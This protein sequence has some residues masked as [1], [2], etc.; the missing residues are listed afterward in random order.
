MTPSKLARSSLTSTAPIRGTKAHQSQPKT[1]G[2]AARLLAV[3]ALSTCAMMTAHAAIPP[4]ERAVLQDIYTYTDGDNWF[5]PSRTGWNGAPGTECQWQGIACNADGDSVIAV[6]LVGAEL[7]GSLP[8]L[9]GLP[10][11]EVFDVRGVGSNHN[12]LYGFIPELSSLHKLQEFRAGNNFMTG[13]IPSLEG[14]GDLR[15]FECYQ[16]QLG[17]NIP[18]LNGLHEL[19]FFNVSRNQ[20]TGSLPALTGLNKLVY[21]DAKENHLTGTLPP[22]VGLTRLDSFFAYSNM[23]SGDVPDLIGLPELTHYS[24]GR[25]LL[26]GRIGILSDLPKLVSFDVSRN[27]LT[28]SLP[29]LDGLSS[30]QVLDAARNRL[31]GNVPDLSAASAL[32]GFFIQFNQLEGSL[33][34]PPASLVAA[35]QGGGS[36]ASATICPNRL[37]PAS[38]PPSSADLDWNTATRTTPWSRDCVADPLWPTSISVTTSLNPALSGQPVTFTTKVW[39]ADPTGTVTLTTQSHRPPT[40]SNPVITLCENVPLQGSMATCTYSDLPGSPSTYLVFADYS[41][42]SQN[43]PIVSYPNSPAAVINVN[44]GPI[45]VSTTANPAQVD[46]PVDITGVAWPGDEDE[47]PMYFYD[48]STLLCGAVPV[49]DVEG[50]MTGHCVIQFAAPG[51]HSILVTRE[52][53]NYQIPSDGFVPL[54]QNVTAHVPFDANQFALTGSWYNPITSGQGVQVVVY[55]DHSGTGIGLLAGSWFTYDADGNQQWLVLQGDLTRAHGSTYDLPV[56]QATGGN[57]ASPPIV[58][59][60][61]IGTASITFHD[62]THFSLTF[63]LDDGRAGTIPMVRL[64]RT[65]ACSTTV[66]ATPPQEMPE[67]YGDVLHS[68]AWYDPET[69]GQGIMVDVVPSQSVFA[70]SWFTYVPRA[71]P[72]TGA[73]RQRWFGLQSN[74]Y[75]P[76]DLNLAGVPII[77][78]SGGL[79]NQPSTITRTQ[80]GTADVEFT[81]CTSMTLHYTFTEGEFSGLS[82]SIIERAIAPVPGCP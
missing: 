58:A 15:I 47:R 4:Q 75:R 36:P 23:L 73:S 65:S 74:T 17:G 77:V 38:T 24:V 68:G 1:G 51:R 72:S 25:N 64:T 26:D 28:G 30:L 49:H 76:G 32:N 63:S 45:S 2:A 69:S 14:L 16:C 70:A 12:D 60:S 27:L 81:S 33:P 80:V 13:N 59:A 11:L 43:S 19:E 5:P 44:Y 67:N 42:D 22:L 41:G 40:E 37:N 35:A 57:F 20:L 9:N 10:N 53:L 55:P 79:F 21:F 46:E 50:R 29:S 3:I 78:A 7:F 8:P 56:G 31:S 18:S 34:L 62:C 82:G 66:P 54:I 52:Q 61:I 71:D 6:R 39:G 48:G